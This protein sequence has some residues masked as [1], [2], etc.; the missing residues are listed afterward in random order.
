MGRR[1]ARHSCFG[2]PRVGNLVFTS[3]GFRMLAEGVG[4][5]GSRLEGSGYWLQVSGLGAW[6]Q[7]VGSCGLRVE[8]RVLSVEGA[9]RADV[10]DGVEGVP[11][12]AQ[13]QRG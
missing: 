7:R 2:G 10:V 4:F 13:P 9:E 6:P 3:E 5:R 12:P 8:C 11:S 1:G